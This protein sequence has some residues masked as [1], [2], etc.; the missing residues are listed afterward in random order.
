MAP[1]PRLL[2]WEPA[3]PPT[4][5]LAWPP[6]PPTAI[7][8]GHIIQPAT[9]HTLTR[10]VVLLLHLASLSITAAANPLP[11]ASPSPTP[12]TPLLFGEPHNPCPSLLHGCPRMPPQRSP[13]RRV[14][15]PVPP[16]SPSPPRRQRPPAS[17]PSRWGAPGEG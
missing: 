5:I 1:L 2:R 14:H 3:S 12:S 10:P 6:R 8:C 15:P 17:T 4:P 9:R 13:S 11:K 16:S 7:G